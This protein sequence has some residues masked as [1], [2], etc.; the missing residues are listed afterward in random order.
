MYKNLAQ[1]WRPQRFAEVIGQNVVVTVLKNSIKSKMTVPSYLF[2]GPQGTGKTSVARIL[3]RT[4]NCENQ[5][6]GEACLKCESCRSSFD[7]SNPDIIEIDGASW[8]KLDDVRELARSLD[9]PPIGKRKIIIIDEV[10]MLI[11]EAFNALLKTIE[12]PPEYVTFVFATTEPDKVLPTIVSRCQQFEFKRIPVKL[13]S[14][15]LEHICKEE[16]IE[17]EKEAL[18]EVAQFSEGSLR[19]AET[20]AEKLLF[21]SG[22]KILSENIS[23]ALGISSEKAIDNYLALI[24]SEDIE[25]LNKFLDDLEEKNYDPYNFAKRAAM[26]AQDKVISGENVHIWFNIADLLI[27]GMIKSRM[28]GESMLFLRNATLKAAYAKKIDDAASFIESLTRNAQ[29]S[30]YNKIVTTDSAISESKIEYNT[31]QK[32]ETVPDVQAVS[33]SG[34]AVMHNE[35]DNNIWNELLDNL[36]EGFTKSCL[37][38]DFELKKKN[39]KWYLVQINGN[40]GSRKRIEDEFGKINTV[41]LRLTSFNIESIINGEQNEK[42]IVSNKNSEIVYKKNDTEDKM[43]KLLKEKYD[44]AVVWKNYV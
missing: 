38:N 18:N 13:I 28:I 41:F 12:E 34:N 40:G 22:G 10:H 36:D 29:R 16:N 20:A 25:G 7:S 31:E 5:E 44:A 2:N 17:Y 37:K 19:N 42:K 4:L 23:K 21:Y 35:N 33:S 3:A 1:K 15:Q 43:V 8:R 9:Y 32:T 26:R 11:K 6:A 30:N 24:A 27:S 39:E 14:D